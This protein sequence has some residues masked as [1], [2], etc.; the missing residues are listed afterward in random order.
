MARTL[1]GNLTG[2]AAA[3]Q[4][5]EE[6][7]Q[8]IEDDLKE[9][10]RAKTWEDTEYWP[11]VERLE[12]L[13]PYFNLWF[14]NRPEKTKGEMLPLMKQRIEEILKEQETLKV[15]S[16]INVDT[17]ADAKRCRRFNTQL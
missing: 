10:Q 14:W 7:N 8:R 17:I 13:D 3:T 2:R 9:A 1:R 15:Q 12:A 11:T 16:E 4:R 6:W 5:R